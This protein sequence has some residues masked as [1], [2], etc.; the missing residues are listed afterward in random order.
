ML[1]TSNQYD[2]ILYIHMAK[3]VFES[4]DLVRRIY[5]FGDP[6]HRTFTE[7]LKWDLRQWP[8][9]FMEKYMERRTSMDVFSYTIDEYL[10]EYSSKSIHRL[11]RTCRRCYCCARHNVRKYELVD[12]A[13]LHMA[14][15]CVFEN[16]NSECDCTCRI[17]NRIASI[18][19][20]RR[21]IAEI[22]PYI[23]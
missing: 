5:S 18:H 19:M 1:K 11:L 23:E 17:L 7:N 2:S 4:E 12:R 21:N 6:F 14:D 22:E 20:F 10:N 9:V 15:A 13:Y 8:S 16:G 3:Q